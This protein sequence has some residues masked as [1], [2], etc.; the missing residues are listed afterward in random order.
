MKTLED[1]IAQNERDK[2]ALDLIKIYLDYIENY[3]DIQNQLVV[4]GEPFNSKAFCLMDKQKDAFKSLWL[5]VVE[6]IKHQDLSSDVWYRFF[7]F[8]HD[9]KYNGF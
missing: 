9:V 4:A 8:R 1:L 2:H 3:K 5:S 7:R 6:D